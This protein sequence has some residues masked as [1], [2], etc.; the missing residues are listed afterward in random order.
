MLDIDEDCLARV[1]ELFCS[2][3]GKD[4]TGFN[5]GRVALVFFKALFEWLTAIY[6]CEDAL[7]SSWD[8]CR[9]TAFIFL[10]MLS[11]LLLS[12]FVELL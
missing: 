1:K 6:F 10:N 2:F 12:G 4:S 3:S 11:N 8:D 7:F 9:Y 5:S